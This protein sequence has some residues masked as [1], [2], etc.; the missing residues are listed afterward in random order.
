MQ[1]RKLREEA[2]ALLVAQPQVK[3]SEEGGASRAALEQ[4]RG[5]SSPNPSPGPSANPNPNPNS[6]PNPNPHQPLT[7]RAGCTIA[8]WC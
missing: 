3:V 1:A 7:R 6:N 5:L 8:P 4:A 2:D